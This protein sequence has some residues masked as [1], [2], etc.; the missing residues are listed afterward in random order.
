MGHVNEAVPAMTRLKASNA[1]GDVVKGEGEE[2]EVIVD[3]DAAAA[4]AV[5][6]EDDKDETERGSDGEYM[7]L[8]LSKDDLAR[9]EGW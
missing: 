2:V 5:A 9:K 3:D 6:D 1:G 4:T 7:L 8:A